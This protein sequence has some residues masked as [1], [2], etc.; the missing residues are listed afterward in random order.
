GEAPDGPARR[1]HRSDPRGGDARGS[2]PRRLTPG[3]GADVTDDA[4]KLGFATRAI[5]AGQ[6]PDATTGAIVTPVY[7]TVSYAHDAVDA[8]KGWAYSRSGNPT[9]AAL[10]A[11]IA[12][13]EGAH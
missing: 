11:C 3:G 1:A 8:N 6:E 7:Q 9:R 2:R 13:L 12:S 5:H 10:E 4:R